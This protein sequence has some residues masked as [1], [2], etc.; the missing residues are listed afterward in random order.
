MTGF[1]R[2]AGPAL[3]LYTGCSILFSFSLT[4]RPRPST[5]EPGNASPATGTQ[6]PDRTLLRSHRTPARGARRLELS[7]K[8]H[9]IHSLSHKSSFQMIKNHQHRR[10]SPHTRILMTHSDICVWEVDFS[11]LA[12][13]LRPLAGLRPDAPAFTESVDTASRQARTTALRHSP[14]T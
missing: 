13:T 7:R 11:P 2:T 3:K 5:A 9:N 8:T 10:A 14:R 12:D 6:R 1:G 4:F